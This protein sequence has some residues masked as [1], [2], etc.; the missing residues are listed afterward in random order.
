[1]SKQRIHTTLAVCAIA[2]AVGFA[3]APAFAQTRSPND[4]GPVSLP[5]G[6]KLDGGVKSS[7]SGSSYVGRS[8]NDGGPGA[9]PTAAQVGAAGAQNKTANQASAPHVGRPLNDG[10]M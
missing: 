7:S 5:S 4:G 3:S 8:A 9:Q 2:L 6:A 10:G 1:M